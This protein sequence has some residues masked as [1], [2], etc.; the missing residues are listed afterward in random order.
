[1]VTSWWDTA[2]WAPLPEDPACGLWRALRAGQYLGDLMCCEEAGA[3][4]T[5]GLG[6]KHPDQCLSGAYLRHVWVC[7]DVP[8]E[9]C[10]ACG[11]A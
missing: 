6:L 4:P 7:C 3:G 1:M 10:R 8:G 5:Q 2:V 9:G 11:E